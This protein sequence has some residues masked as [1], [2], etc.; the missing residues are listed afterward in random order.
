MPKNLP[1]SNVVL[2]RWCDQITGVESMCVFL[3]SRCGCRTHCRK[4]AFYLPCIGGNQWERSGGGS[5]GEE[6]EE[7]A[8]REERR[9]TSKGGW[10]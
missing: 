3:H 4:R 8:V 6:W 2:D 9:K 7:G 5:A 10:P 1:I